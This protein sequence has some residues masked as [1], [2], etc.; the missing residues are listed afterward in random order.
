MFWLRVATN[1]NAS[2]ICARVLLTRAL[3]DK[4]NEQRQRMIENE[5]EREE[6]TVWDRK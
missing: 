5:R 6:K 2:H 4:G 1:A 3:C